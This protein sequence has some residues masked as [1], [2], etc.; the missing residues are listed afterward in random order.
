[1]AMAMVMADTTDMDTVKIKIN[2]F[3]FQDILVTQKAP[4]ETVK[5]LTI[6][7]EQKTIYTLFCTFSKTNPHRNRD[8]V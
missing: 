5:K 2:D 7:Q 8:T 6:P 3:L 1:M 4:A